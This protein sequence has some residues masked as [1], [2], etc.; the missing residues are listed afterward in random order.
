MSPGLSIHGGFSVVDCTIFFPHVFPY[1]F[2]LAFFPSLVF[3]RH[4]FFHYGFC[5]AVNAFS[6]PVPCPMLFTV[7]VNMYLLCITALRVP[8]FAELVL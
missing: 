3:S 2:L 4:V 6:F 1:L 7:G 5:Q 8:V